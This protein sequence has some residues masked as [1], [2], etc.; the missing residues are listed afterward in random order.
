MFRVEDSD[1]LFMFAGTLHSIVSCA[2]IFPSTTWENTLGAFVYYI[3]SEVY[4]LG[5]ATFLFKQIFQIPTQE[6]RR[7]CPEKFV[8]THV[9]SLLCR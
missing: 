5:N 3:S 4:S 2:S 7:T 9:G 1:R 8:A 6:G